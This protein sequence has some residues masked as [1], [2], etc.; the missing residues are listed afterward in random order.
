MPNHQRIALGQGKVFSAPHLRRRD[1]LLQGWRRG[2]QEIYAEVPAPCQQDRHGSYV[3]RM[4]DQ[5]M[6]ADLVRP[7]LAHN[8][9]WRGAG[10]APPSV[11]SPFLARRQQSPSSGDSEPSCLRLRDCRR[12]R[13]KEKSLLVSIDASFGVNRQSHIQSLNEGRLKLAD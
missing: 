3:E 2:T 4:G 13:V 5:R 12:G 10:A 7:R 11:E 9:L 1:R 6:A 8:H